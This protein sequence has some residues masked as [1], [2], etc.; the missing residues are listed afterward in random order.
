MDADRAQRLA[1]ELRELAE[2]EHEFVVAGR[3]D[4]LDELQTRRDVVLAELPD[5]LSEPA[6]DTLRHALAVQ[7]RV[8]V[9]LREAMDATARELA[10]TVR[11][12]TAANGYAP[13]G[14]DPRR[15]LDRTA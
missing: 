9:A 15:V 5:Q 11:G 12:R 14:L 10:T 1:A 3:V 6:R 2:R 7:E 4:E 13:A 8:S